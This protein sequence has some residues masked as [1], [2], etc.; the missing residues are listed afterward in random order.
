MNNS[1]RLRLFVIAIFVGTHGVKLSQASDPAE[2]TKVV[3]P[4]LVKIEISRRETR[5]VGSGFVV[6]SDGIIATTFH[7]V[8]GADQGKVVFE[9]GRKADI[10]GYVFKKPDLDVVMLKISDVGLITEL[11]LC[12]NDPKKG[13]EVFAFGNPGSHRDQVPSGVVVEFADVDTICR[14]E[15][16]ND[17]LKE[18][19][20]KFSSDAK[21]IRTDAKISDL[22][23]GGPLINPKGQVVGINTWYKKEEVD[24]LNFAVSF[25]TLK[26]M[27]DT[28]PDKITPLSSLATA[29]PSINVD[30]TRKIRID[31]PGDDKPL[32]FDIFFSFLD[33]LNESLRE[34]DKRLAKGDEGFFIEY[35]NKNRFA[36]FFHRNGKLNDFVY[37][38]HENGNLMCKGCYKNDQR[39]GDFV[40]FNEL[41]I[42]LFAAQYSLNRKNGYL[43]LFKNGSPWL[44]QQYSKSNLILSYLCANKE[45]LETVQHKPKPVVPVVPSNEMQKAFD[46]LADLEKKIKKSEV[47]IMDTV[48]NFAEDIRRQR[49]NANAAGVT[50]NIQNRSNSRSNAQRELI[51]GLRGQSGL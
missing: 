41:R 21:W 6:R 31:L 1:V 43:C 51:G 23:I 17:F 16:N 28:L 14:R 8:D 11:P 2:V 39:D 29:Q 9:D 37:A 12:E 47:Q 33:K 46:E 45:V 26:E 30:D 34:Q 48:D 40:S 10:L 15:E 25:L 27:L 38:M 42:P 24:N 4:A 19:K 18:F 44:I 3:R 22:N 5:T 13:S 36:T 32:D 7:I 50:Q 35:P 49:A 20:M